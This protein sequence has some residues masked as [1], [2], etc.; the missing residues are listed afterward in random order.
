MNDAV[1][2]AET[3]LQLNETISIH[4]IS[5]VEHYFELLDIENVSGSKNSQASCDL[6]I[7]LLLTKLAES[8]T[9]VSCT[10]LHEQRGSPH[11]AAL[12]E[13]RASIR[14]N[15]AERHSIPELA[16]TLALSVSH[17]QYLYKQ[18]F[19]VSCHEDIISARLDMAEY[20]L[21]NT[22]L[23]LRQIAEQC[24]YEN[25]VH[26]IRQFRKMRGMTA[27]EYRKQNR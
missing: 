15:P 27:G 23:P 7:R 12:R 20:Y 10:D 8:A 16:K 1:F 26:F 9:G 3:G 25:D 6:L 4:D 2:I 21:K 17:F 19:G 22:A 11:R 13:L 5:A 14:R 24:G 18:E